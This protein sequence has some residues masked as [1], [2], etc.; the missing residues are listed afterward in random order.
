MGKNLTPAWKQYLSIKEDYIDSILLYRMGD[1][2]EAFDNDA[3]ILSSQLQIT[4]TKKEFGKGQ[5]H[6]LA[7]IPFHSLDNHLPILVE[8]GYRIAI[9]EQIGSEP[10]SQGII[11][12]RTHFLYHIE[13]YGYHYYNSKIIISRQYNNFCF[14][15]PYL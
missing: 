8:K 4:L 2:Y 13:P 14:A 12:R 3:E 5:V 10:N 9:C 6:L 1:F 15:I 7:G 11:D